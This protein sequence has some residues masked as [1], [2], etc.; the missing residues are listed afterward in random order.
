LRIDLDERR[1]ALGTVAGDWDCYRWNGIVTLVLTIGLLEKNH[2]RYVDY[3]PVSLL[4]DQSTNS[5][6]RY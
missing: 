1:V 4:F 6:S 5:T 2:Y 3:W